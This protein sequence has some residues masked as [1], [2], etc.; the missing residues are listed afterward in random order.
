MPEKKY[1]GRDCELS[2]TG[3][4]PEGRSLDSWSVTRAVLPKIES[5]ARSAH[6]TV[7]SQTNHRSN[8]GATYYGSAHADDCLRHWTS[9][10]QCVY[11]DMAHVEVCTAAT[12]YPRTF[13]AQSIAMLLLAERARQLA[14]RDALPGTRYELSAS[15]ADLLDPSI[16]FGSHISVSVSRA[17]WENLFIDQRYPA[18]LGFVASA[19]AAAIPFFG[20][21]Y[22]L[23]VQNGDVIFSLSARAHHISKLHTLATTEKWRRGLLNSRRESHAVSQERLHLIG[24]DYSIADSA[25]LASFLQCTL[26]AAE[27]GFCR[28][29]LI[30]PIR[31]MHQWSWNLDVSTGKMPATATLVDGSE[32]T[33]PQFMRKLAETLL[34]MCEGGLI[35]DAVAPQAELF[36]PRIIDLARYAEE[37]SLIRCATHLDW[38]AKLVY[39]LNVDGHFEDAALRIADHDF[40]NTNQ[41][42]GTIWRL[43]ERQLI[44]PLVDMNDALDSIRNAPAESRDWGR[45]RIIE[46]FPNDIAAVDWSYVELCG[47][48]GWFSPRLR[49]EFPRLD[50]WNRSTFEPII[51]SVRNIEELRNALR[52]Q[53]RMISFYDDGQI[54]V[55]A[56]TPDASGN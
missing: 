53:E 55:L 41:Q 56:T 12:L 54:D 15:N 8:A 1:I 35:E 19:I 9:A 3:I 33:L 45:G 7:W 14:E 48:T 38:A 10:G 32:V 25:L 30:D 29:N 51:H 22:L 37:G 47:N 21:G 36:L 39:L 43:W 27:E 34:E 4:D 46:Q 50:S 16:S 52:Q 40:A 31:A 23:P 17:L 13:A 18:V 6:A 5:A 28:L 11:A 24:F 2:T 26:A 49:V 42:K 20:S 44:D